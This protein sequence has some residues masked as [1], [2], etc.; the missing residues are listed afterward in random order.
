MQDFI[1]QKIYNGRKCA[2]N[3]ENETMDSKICSYIIAVK[4]AGTEQ[5]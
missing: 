1:I 2:N 4:T 3:K 5:E